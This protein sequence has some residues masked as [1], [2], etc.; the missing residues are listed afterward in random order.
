MA[1]RGATILAHCPARILAWVA[2][3]LSPIVTGVLLGVAMLIAQPAHADQHRPQPA[4]AP[5]ERPPSARP[6]RGRPKVVL[7]RLS[8][9]V[10]VDGKLFERHL[11]RVLRR[12]TRRADWGTGRGH[13]IEYRFA[14]DK[15]DFRLRGSV[16]QVECEASGALPKGRTAKTRIS[17]GGHVGK[18]RQLVEQVLTVVARGIVTRLAEMERVR[19]GQLRRLRVLTPTGSD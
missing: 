4:D 2:V 16:L 14:I 18:R 6:S 12:E 11:R 3:R 7:D 8:M 13:R 1:L 5:G 10:V 9:P 17:F 19:R 15:L